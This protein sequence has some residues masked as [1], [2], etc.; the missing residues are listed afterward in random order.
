MPDL[1]DKALDALIAD[2]HLAADTLAETDSFLTGQ[3]ILREAA[4]ALTALRGGAET[5]RVAEWNKA[6]T[7]SAQMA[8]LWSVPEDGPDMSEAE[9]RAFADGKLHAIE[10][11]RKLLKPALPLPSD[12][13][14][15]DIPGL[16]ASQPGEASVSSAPAHD[17]VAEAAR[18]ARIAAGLF[19]G[20]YD[21]NLAK[22]NA[23]LQENRHE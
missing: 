13:A 16:R 8:G 22:I 10:M 19:P 21:N 6:V 14:P 18:V 11:V 20:G 7:A 9:A 17:P 3:A 1:T 4:D 23:A 12:T 15:G 5:M 2:C